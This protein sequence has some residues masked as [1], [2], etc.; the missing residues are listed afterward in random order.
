MS[1]Y[2]NSLNKTAKL[3]GFMFLASLCIPI[4]N[5]V[6][7]LSKLVSAGNPVTTAH[8]ILSNEFSF[9]F[10][11][12]NEL[13][14]S[15]IIIALAI[16]LYR[17]LKPLN[18]VLALTAFTIKLLEASVFALIA[19]FHFVGLLILQDIRSEEMSALF[20]SLVNSHITIT[21]IPGVL[22]GLSLLIFSYLL[23]K[24][25]YVPRLLALFGII[26]YMLVIIFDSMTILLPD[27]SAVLW[28]QII[29]STPICL[30]QLIIGFWLISK[31]LI[32]S[33]NT[34]AQF[35]AKG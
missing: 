8:N 10:N 24:S 29:C 23:L 32:I 1:N 34:T 2:P 7:V 6:F 19:L 12:L 13:L 35:G 22:S 28:V 20:G 21:S 11:I 17:I 33:R 3:A 26:S 27:Y 4:L 14:T 30:F 15:L 9:R 18:M 16:T 31:D 5:W 25:K